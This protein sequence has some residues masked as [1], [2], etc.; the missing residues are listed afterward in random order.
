MFTWAA[1]ASEPWCLPDCKVYEE[2]FE[3]V[4]DFFWAYS[5]VIESSHLLETEVAIEFETRVETVIDTW[6]EVGIKA[7][8]KA[9]LNVG[10]KIVLEAEFVLHVVPALEKVRVVYRSM[11]GKM[12][13]QQH[14]L[15]L[16]LVSLLTLQ[17]Q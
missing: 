15:P 4:C 9:R 8:M 16:L 17:I 2:D 5:G 10:I 7:W 11:L 14:L 12:T 1:V 13:Y 3:S 6:L